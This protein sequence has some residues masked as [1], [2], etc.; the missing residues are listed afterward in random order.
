M[1]AL[2]M[3]ELGFVSGGTDRAVDLVVVRGPAIGLPWGFT[4]GR[5]PGVE[6]NND[7]TDPNAYE[8][9]A[10]IAQTSAAVS[11]YGNIGDWNKSGSNFD[12]TGTVVAGSA[13]ILAGIGAIGGMVA[14]GT[15]IT[16]TGV[17]GSVGGSAL[18][19][20]T[21]LDEYG[22]GFFQ[23]LKAA[24]NVYASNMSNCSG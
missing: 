2:T 7:Y 23:A 18:A 5:R 11:F 20:G 24:G 15:S 17:L 10:A 9:C 6:S 22:E 21:F 19:L 16:A 14:A 4:T 8:A 13:A 1:R 12:E 3:E